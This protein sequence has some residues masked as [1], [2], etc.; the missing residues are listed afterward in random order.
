L[1]DQVNSSTGFYLEKL[2]ITNAADLKS[3]DTACFIATNGSVHPLSVT[4]D[5]DMNLLNISA[6]QDQNAA[7]F[8][9]FEM[10]SIQYLE[11]GKDINYC[12]LTTD[13]YKTSETPD[14]TGNYA[15]V[16]FTSQTM[17]ARDILMTFR[18]LG[19]GVLSIKWTYNDIQAAPKVPF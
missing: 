18:V 10:R 16:V 17:A 15:E 19:S 14:L 5:N 1:N 9:F 4:H 3:I 7:D 8:T 12:N 2:V 6:P 13:F 11:K